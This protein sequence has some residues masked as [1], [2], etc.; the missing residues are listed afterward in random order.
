MTY[1]IYTKIP[2]GQAQRELR[3]TFEVYGAGYTNLGE[4]KKMARDLIRLG[5]Y[6]VRIEDE[7]YRTR[8]LTLNSSPKKWWDDRA[9]P[10]SWSNR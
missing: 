1:T 9:C 8:H 4:C 3:P 7:N 5:A 2:A 6:A 10:K